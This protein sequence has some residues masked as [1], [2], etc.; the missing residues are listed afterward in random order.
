[1]FTLVTILS[2]LTLKKNTDFL[3][4]CGGAYLCSLGLRELAGR[5]KFGKLGSKKDVSVFE[6]LL[7]PYMPLGK[8]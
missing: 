4:G 2:A 3:P 5:E 8:L 6:I 1:M 7:I